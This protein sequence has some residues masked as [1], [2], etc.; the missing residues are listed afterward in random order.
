[1]NEQALLFSS[2]LLT[3]LVVFTR[4]LRNK[5][6]LWAWVLCGSSGGNEKKLV[7]KTQGKNV[8]SF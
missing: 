7:V 2:N 8:A 3:V 5:L 6:G 4:R 1:M